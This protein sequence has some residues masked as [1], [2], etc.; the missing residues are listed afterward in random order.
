MLSSMA[1]TGLST[2]HVSP[3]H[4]SPAHVSA[5][6]AQS[7]YGP[8]YQV[9]AGFIY[10]FAKFIEWPGGTFDNGAD[11]LVLCIVP[12]N[13]ESD[14]FFSLNNKTVGGRKILV[15]KCKNVKEIKDCQILF[16]DSTDREFIREGL[17]SAKGQGILTVGQ[18]KGF[19]QEGG[20]INF[21]TEK[22]RL[23]FEVNLD[24]AQRFGLRLG[25]QILMSAE[26][27]S[28]GQK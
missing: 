20:I 15:R 26:V 14:V 4:L 12:N 16:F 22:G 6:Y 2:T 21:F 19:M 28:K 18:V 3:A 5:A 7:L 11:V 17:L 24:A 23:R 25:S 8:E 9:K 10:N 1:F 13:P 27:I